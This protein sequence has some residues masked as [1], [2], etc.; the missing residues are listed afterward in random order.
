M[1][2]LSRG[3]SDAGAKKASKIGLTALQGD[4]EER[5]VDGGV[6]VVVDDAGDVPAEGAVD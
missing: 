5:S 2:V 6:N 3:F 4:E 1:A